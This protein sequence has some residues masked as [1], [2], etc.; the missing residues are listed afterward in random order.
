MFF[1]HGL[2][3]RLQISFANFDLFKTKTSQRIKTDKIDEHGHHSAN[4]A[5]H[6][7]RREKESVGNDFHEEFERH[8][9]HE[10]VVHDL[11]CNLKSSFPRY[12]K[13]IRTTQEN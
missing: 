7:V 1:H 9:R 4:V 13:K 6:G 10:D 12:M 8:R 5:D 3:S 2:I 11:K